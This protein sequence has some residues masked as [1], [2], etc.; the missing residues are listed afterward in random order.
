MILPYSSTSSSTHAH[1]TVETDRTGILYPTSNSGT[2]P[3]ALASQHYLPQVA[4]DPTCLVEEGPPTCHWQ[5]L[6]A[7]PLHAF[8]YKQAY[9]P[10]TGLCHPFRIDWTF[11]LQAGSSSGRDHT[12]NRL[13]SIPSQDQTWHART[14]H[15]MPKH[16]NP[17]L[18]ARALPSF[19]ACPCCQTWLHACPD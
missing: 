18:P 5:P 9:L 19:P 4:Q 14:K 17:C 3:M 1:T 6:H 13:P 11:S 8:H 12:P 2:C 16:Y 15:A 7:C 10:T